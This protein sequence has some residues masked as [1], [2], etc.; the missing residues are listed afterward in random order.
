MEKNFDFVIL[1]DSQPEGLWLAAGLARRSYSVAIVP[2]QTLGELPPLEALPMRFPEKV[3]N[4]QMDELLFKVGFFKLEES[5]LVADQESFQILQKKH[6]LSLSNQSEK[7][8]TEMEREFPRSVEL[9]ARLRSGEKSKDGQNLSALVAQC[10]ELQKD[11]LGFA[12]MVEME[13]SAGRPHLRRSMKEMSRDWV[14]KHL[15]EATHHFRPGKNLSESFRKFL[16]E[17]ARKWGVQ[18][19]EEAIEVEK[20][21]RKFLLNKKWRANFLVVNTLAAAK[22]ITRY[23]DDLAPDRVTHWLYYD[24]FFCTPDDLPEPLG[25]LSYLQN[26]EGEGES[27]PLFVERDRLRDKA[28]ITLGVW[29]PF[30]DSRIWE[31]KIDAARRSLKRLLPFLS[32]SVWKQIPS[33]FELNEMKGECVRRGDLDR[34]VFDLP[35]EKALTGILRLFRSHRRPKSLRSGVIL[36]APYLTACRDRMDSLRETLST[37]EWFEK[38][39]GRS[40]KRGTAS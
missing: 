33:N 7:W 2:S 9:I 29:L 15:Q 36:V 39:G 3:G 1:G 28:V 5:G 8:F 23:R 40:V 31:S 32:E 30:Q 18:I 6:R 4:R 35:E 26:F 20:G 38:R 10:T 12:E 17:H 34:L 25:E 21:W 13:L 27:Y 37:L 19:L 24:R 11:D 22:L 16:L 14:Q